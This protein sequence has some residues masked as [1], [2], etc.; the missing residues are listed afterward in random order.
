MYAAWVLDDVE[1]LVIRCIVLSD[2]K[3]FSR[4]GALSDA[5]LPEVRLWIGDY[6]FLLRPAFE[7]LCRLRLRR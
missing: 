2:R 7:D 5:W 3:D 4:L 6:P 1:G